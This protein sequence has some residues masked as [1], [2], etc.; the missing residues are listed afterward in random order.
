MEHIM[1]F[2]RLR[3][4]GSLFSMLNQASR[5]VINYNAAHSDF[6][7]QQ[8]QLERYVPKALVYALLWSFAGH[9]LASHEYFCAY[10]NKAGYTAT[11]R[12]SQSPIA[13]CDGQTHGRTYG[14]T[15]KAVYRVADSRLKKTNK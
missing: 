15:D 13:S 7:M 11:S 12:E 3:A 4:L 8:D 6:P 10:L 2:T 5:N 14:R 1:D 9:I